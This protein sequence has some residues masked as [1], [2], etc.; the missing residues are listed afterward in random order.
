SLSNATV[1]DLNKR[2]EGLPSSDQEEIILQLNERQK[3]NW[4]ELTPEEKKAAWYISYGEWGP[5][6]PVHQKG[7]GLKIFGGVVLGL[8][9]A[10]GLFVL[11]RLNAPAQPKTMTREWQEASD[12]Y[13]KS[14]NA[15]PF[16][17][18]SQI[19]SK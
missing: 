12:E 7:D 10:S 2:W 17:S 18:Y 6:R 13:L 8:G 15:N 16:T 4:K 1:A 11:F 5:R 14:K 3:L 9:I 19:Q